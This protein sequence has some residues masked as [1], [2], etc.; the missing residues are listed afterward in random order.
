MNSDLDI[1]P[2]WAWSGTRFEV[3]GS[4]EFMFFERHGGGWQ[5]FDADG[6]P[7]VTTQGGFANPEHMGN[8]ID[9]IRT[10]NVP[11]GDIAECHLSTSLC[12]YA[13]ASYRV[14]R[15]LTIDAATETFVNDDEANALLKREGREPYRMPEWCELSTRPHNLLILPLMI[16][17][18]VG[19]ISCAIR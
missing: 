9:C 15:K 16:G 6:K 4:K 2:D 19:A 8:F 13:N 10:R 3:Y 7:S 17:G 1:L 12:H 11:N 5:T 18:K 14:G